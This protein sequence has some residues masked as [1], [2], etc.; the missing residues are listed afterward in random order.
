ML[1][2]F[3]EEC[4]R[5]FPLPSKDPLGELPRLERGGAWSALEVNGFQPLLLMPR[6]KNDWSRLTQPLSRRASPS[7]HLVELKFLPS[8]S[9]LGPGWI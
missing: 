6:E 7:S 5:T 9:H 4:S 8:K 2:V 1:G 3:T